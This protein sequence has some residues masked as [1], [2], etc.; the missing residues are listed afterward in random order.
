MDCSA[1]SCPE[2]DFLVSSTGNSN[3]K[4]L[5]HSSSCSGDG[6]FSKGEYDEFGPII[7]HR[8]CFLA[9]RASCRSAGVLRGTSE[10]SGERCVCLWMQTQRRCGVA[11]ATCCGSGILRGR[12]ASAST[13]PRFGVWDPCENPGRRPNNR[14]QCHSTLR[15]IACVVY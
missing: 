2:F 13:T 11:S 3:N 7:V 15:R 1:Y 10:D 8:K 12:V 9:H 14:A 6:S 4:G 5:M